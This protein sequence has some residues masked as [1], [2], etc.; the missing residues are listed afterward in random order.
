[1]SQFD[2]ATFM[3]EPSEDTF[4]ALKK[5]ELIS[6]AKHLKLEVKTAMRKH[7]IQNIVLKHLVS[8]G[9][10]KETVLE[11]YEVPKLGLSELDYKLE[12]QKMEMRERREEKERQERLEEKEQQERLQE[13]E[14]QERLEEKERQERLEKE[15]ME[16]QHELEMKK[17]EVQLKLGSDP[18]AEKSSAKFDVTK[19]I[20]FVPPFQQADVDKYF[21]HFE[22]V[23]GNLKWPK[24]YWVMLLQSV[25]VGKAREIYIQ[26]S[27]EQATSYDTVKELILKG[28]ELVPEA[29]R[30]KFRSC[31]KL[32][33]QTYVEFA[34]SKEQLFD[35]WCHSQKVDKDHDKLRQLIL[36]EEFKRCIHSDV[37]TFVDEQKAETLEDAA[38]LAD[39]F[40]L[41][42]KVTFVEKPKRPYPPPGQDPPPLLPHRPGNHR[43]RQSEESRQK[44]NPG[45]SSAN[46]SNFSWSRQDKV[47]S[48]KPFKPLTCFYCRKDGHVLSNC[49]EKL[50]MSRQQ[51]N[52]ESKPTGFIATSLSLP[53]AGEDMPPNCSDV[54]T[55][56]S[57]IS[58][59]SA[60]PK[61]VMDVFEPFIHQGSVSL[62][63][64]MSD[65]KQ[66]KIL[67]DTGASQSLLL[68]NTLLFSEES[69]IGASVLI[70][71]INCSEYSP[72]PLHTVYLKSS[73]VTGPVKVGIQ[74]SLP[75]E[76][77]HFILGN[78]LAGD[79][80]V[81]NA[82]VTEK[83]CLVEFPD[84]V[85]KEIPGLY[86]ACV[87]TRA[88]SKKKENS[89]DVITLAETVIGRV[90]EGEPPKISGSEPVEVIA[91]GSLSDKADK[92]STS[93]LIAEQH[94]D[95]ELSNLFLRVV[96]ENEV[97]QN[98]VCLFTKNG[99]LMRKWRPPD[100]SIEDEWAVKHQI[101]IPKSYRQ[102]ILSMAHETPLAGHMGINK[103]CQKILNH[104]YWPSLRKDVVEFCKS[105]HACQMVG[106]PNQSIPKA[107]L[108][109]I[110]AVQEP[111]SRII[112]DCVGPLP[113]TR[114]GNQYL[115]TIMCASTRF[116][117]AIP[118]R[119]IKAK[120]IV[121]ALTKFFT[122]V[123]L[124][125]SIQSDQGSNFMSGV[126][127]QVMHELGITQYKSSAYHP[128]SQGALERW[129]QTLKTMMRIYCFETEKDWDEG[130]HLLLFAARES[131]QESLGFSP[132][133]LVF[134]HTVRGPLKLLKEKLLQSS[135]N[136]SIN[137]LQY[138][139]DFRTK[140][141]RAC[142]LARANLSSS[143]K[144]MKNKYDVDAVEHSFKPGQ[145]VL[146]LLPVP[147]NP[148]NARFFGPY[149][150]QKKLSNLNYLVVTPDRRKQT[151]LCHV[152]MLKPYVE[153]STDVVLQPASVNV[154]VSESKV[155]LDS[156]LSGD[157]FSPTDTTR[158]TNTD[159]LRN[160]DSKLSH[161]SE[162][163]RQDLEKLLLE[164]KHLFPDVP[165]RTDQMYHDVDVGNAEPVKQ[166]PYRLNPSK[167][168]YLK[169]EIKYLLEN[170]F[171]EPSNSSWS[172]PCIL[173]PKPDGSYRMCTDYR[174]VNCVTKTDTF[175][176]PRMDDCI[177]KVGKA[178]YV[179]K[180]DL[181]K[182]FWQVP[183]TD[184][185]KEISAF[186]TPDGLFQYKVM[187]FGMKNSPASFQRL[188]NKVIAD[189]EGCE[190]Y[191]DDVIIYS[192]T[193]EEHL[194]I[195]REFFKRLSRAMLTINLSKSEFGQAQVTYLGHVVGQGEV[196]PVSAK[197]EAIAKFPQ[198][199]S[200]KQ[201]MRFLGMAGYY[202]RFCPNF[203]AVAE[204]LTQLLSKRVK[205]IWSERCD[206]AF[207]ELKAMLQSAPVLAAP[208]FRSPFKLAVDA[209][210]V[211]TGAVLLQED[212]EGVEHPVCYFSKKFNKS[213][214]NYST[215]EKECLA[216]V[217]A[218]QQFEVYVSSSGLPIVVYSDH[219]PLVFIHKMKNRNQR[220][221]RWSL[222]LQEYVLEIRHIKGKDNVIADCLSRV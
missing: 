26:L 98:P 32:G 213:Q 30:Q 62:S 193:W 154:V 117:E 167:Q 74:P 118:L 25:L 51:Y 210:D 209:S 113:K 129:H 66:I 70:R 148:L 201:L 215:I 168:K 82:I 53:D 187:P 191:I 198:P 10:F 40:S 180:F 64:D 2:A 35:R 219:N 172:S 121:K 54:K 41:C 178:R 163:Q 186:V 37:R 28:Y 119:N 156:E 29:Y 34:R 84:P 9:I 127:Q 145:K 94:K 171:I 204:P 141:F 207:E 100:V 158:L 3:S 217:L 108:Q 97:S 161:L 166:H 185:A 68:S 150:I 174:K 103:T 44:Q 89:E 105:C 123:G 128:Q 76:G 200:K 92:M 57:L 107:P 71:G 195:I 155:E 86:P 39:G 157:G 134:G 55:T 6:L 137:L 17:L 72:V 50:K 181:L 58:E 15:K 31:E 220:L 16:L 205:F 33:Y 126:F 177:D 18:C 175:P 211:A 214:R 212:D 135:N 23:A 20:K 184:R 48:G 60:P 79:K 153:R 46:R 106:K 90:L 140:L 8:E 165:T 162:S 222:M 80:V 164:F 52:A 19:H 192:D 69:S 136:E 56:S 147:G 131:V 221:L 196:K 159:V 13:K 49:P 151:Q 43:N 206:K 95:P 122:L 22:K 91:E 208:D 142:E 146:A 139:S 189:L 45:N 63:S 199:V 7:Q 75:F 111:F 160:L 102:E 202:R 42:H 61:P 27:V 114:S 104:F 218:L 132:F 149:V 4:A 38:R 169:E 179:T 96:D 65:S 143:Q 59:V 24:E 5:D 194:R 14:R 130:I 138:V 99:V 144:S 120:T 83:P 112:V 85:E 21:L 176:I 110:P 93:Q 133:E 81:V 11:K 47:T 77:V 125:S 73:L 173:V 124:P 88:M 12:L 170:D 87:V 115:L 67:R 109:P 197:V 216:L 188:I 152:N 36:I 116:P 1:M 190:A 78:D 203:A 183:L 182:G 101:V